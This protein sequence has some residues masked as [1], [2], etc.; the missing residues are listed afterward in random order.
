MP[1]QAVT[2]HTF[3]AR[4]PTAWR[5]P[6][7]GMHIASSDGSLGKLEASRARSP[8]CTARTPYRPASR[9]ASAAAMSLDLLVLDGRAGLGRVIWYLSP[10]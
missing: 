9:R 3:Y 7:V 8:G 10:R 5:V 1:Q 6:R 2:L 4:S